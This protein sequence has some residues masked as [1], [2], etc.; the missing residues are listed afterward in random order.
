MTVAAVTDHTRD[1]V[2]AEQYSIVDSRT[3]NIICAVFVNIRYKCQY[4]KSNILL[5]VVCLVLRALVEVIY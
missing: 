4:I 2:W 5:S 3:L 1:L